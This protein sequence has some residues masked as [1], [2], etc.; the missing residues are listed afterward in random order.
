[1][2][3]LRR[4]RVALEDENLKKNRYEDVL[5]LGNS[6]VVLGSSKDDKLLGNGYTNVSFIMPASAGNVSW[7]IAT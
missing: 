1:M 3:L 7:F 4:C 5:P 6:R 2:G